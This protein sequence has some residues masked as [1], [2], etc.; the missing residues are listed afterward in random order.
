MSGSSG[1]AASGASVLNNSTLDVRGIEAGSCIGGGGTV[2]VKRLI[3]GAVAVSTRVEGTWRVTY[4]G[5]MTATM[6][7]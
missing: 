1:R 5:L 2:S 3:T 6:P 7:P 4:P